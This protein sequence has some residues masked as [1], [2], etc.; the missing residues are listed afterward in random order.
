M[1]EG[2]CA[3][4]CSRTLPAKYVDKIADQMRTHN[5]NALLIVGGFE[6]RS[7]NCQ[8]GANANIHQSIKDAKNTDDTHT[9]KNIAFIAFKY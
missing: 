3:H 2:N 6:V 5:I 4:L 8:R 7:P 9:C 1:K